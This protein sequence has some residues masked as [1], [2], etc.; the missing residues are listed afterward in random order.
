MKLER[1]RNNLCSIFLSQLSTRIRGV[2][3]MLVEI[4]ERK[5][6]LPKNE[7]QPLCHRCIGK[8]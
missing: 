7:N 2:D 3:S 4:C 5:M 8:I 1:T 6:P